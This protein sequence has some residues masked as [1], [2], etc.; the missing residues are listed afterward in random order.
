MAP[1]LTL[2]VGMSLFA[3]ARALPPAAARDVATTDRIALAHA[4]APAVALPALAEGAVPPSGFERG[5]RER[6]RTGGGAG[7]RLITPTSFRVEMREPADRGPHRQDD[8]LNAA[9]LSA[10][11]AG[12][13]SAPPTAPPLFRI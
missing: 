7:E 11:R 3:S 10:E 6:R 8:P 2:V 9:R 5:D 13:S 4:N 12:R 1:I